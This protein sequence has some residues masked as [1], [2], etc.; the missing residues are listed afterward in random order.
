MFER[1]HMIL[2]EGLAAKH[3]PG[4]CYAIGCRD[5]VFVREVLGNRQ[6]FPTPIAADLG[7]LYDMASITKIVGTSM[8]ALRFVEEGRLGLHDELYRYYDNCPED[9]K[10]IVVRSLMTH[11]SGLCPHMRLQKYD[12]DPKN[13]VR[14]ILN[15]PLGY[16]TE[17]AVEYSCMG[18]IVLA[19]ILAKIGDRPL[20]ELVQKYVFDP[21][22]METACYNPKV[23]N[24]AAT[25]YREY[26]KDVNGGY[27][28]GFVHDENA[29]FLGG[30]SG[31][32]GIF[33]S[34]DDMIRYTRMIA[35]RGR[36]E[37]KTF[38]TERM[39]EK[40]IYN[41]TPGKA[42]ARGL[43]FQLCANEYFPGGDLMSIGSYGHTGFTGT[44]VYVD[45]DTGLWGIVLTNAVHYGR[46]R[47]G[48][49]RTRRLFFN[50]IINEYL[51]GKQ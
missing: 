34:I 26:L 2:E 29:W 16:P 48:L 25:E 7:T 24:V 47:D 39:F 44:S 18:M 13:A 36:F 40:A 10:H 50:S 14:S 46:G 32:A 49:F 19:D 33:A 6:D 20:D 17:T 1:S 31:N 27:Q 3:F 38:L 8:V 22:G 5:E 42:Q 21:L 43:G 45:K 35:C 11:S 15:A 9:K 12:P 51:R 37:G 28:K 41:Y 23:E 30:V 4:V